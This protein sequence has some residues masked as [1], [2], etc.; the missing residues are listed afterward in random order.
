[1]NA[2]Q[3]ELKVI[4]AQLVVD[5]PED[6]GRRVARIRTLRDAMRVSAEHRGAAARYPLLGIAAFVLFMTV[7]NVAGVFLARTAAQ[8]RE[9]RVRLALGAP[10]SLLATLLLAQSLTLSFAAGAGGIVVSH[11]FIQLASS[12]L[13]V[14]ESGTALILDERF[15]LFALLLSLLAGLLVALLPVWRLA[16]L[17]PREVLS[18]VSVRGAGIARTGG[19]QRSMVVGQVAL[20]VVLLSSTGLLSEELLHLVTSKTGFDPKSLLVASL[21]IGM[22]VSPEAS[23]EQAR[24]VER[25]IAQLGG[26]SSAALG[27]LPAEGYSYRLENG[28]KLREER[29]PIPYRVSPRYFATLRVRLVAGREFNP[30]DRTGSV[31]VGIVNRRAA[32]IWW[33]KQNP[34]GKSVYMARRGGAEEWVRIV[35]VVDNERVNRSMTSEI[36]PVFYRPFDQLTAERR[37]VQA[38]ARTNYPPETAFSSVNRVIEKACGGGGWRGEGIATMESM[39]G[40][41]LAEQRFRTWALSLFSVVALFLAALGIYGVVATMVAQRTAEIGI[42]IALGARRVQV[43]TLVFRQGAGLAVTGFALGLAG[44]FAMTRI[45]QPLLVRATGFDVRM[46]LAAGVVLVG[47]VLVACYFPA[48]RAARI[49]PAP[50]L[51]DA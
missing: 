33:P 18:A 22:T 51:H 12:R 15:V 37:R 7:L 32:E 36:L 2:A 49:D 46:P 23:V 42:R 35:G 30:S 3:S 39:L 9:L 21:P 34:I 24:Q 4:S 14:A 26:I 40:A 17:E 28:D 5:F 16:R 1:L 31:P 44:S 27:G 25:E 20:A 38:F 47:A 13:Q 50:L 29:Y 48:Q 11:W 19:V 8:A 6:Y 45:L 10:R 43:L 41:T